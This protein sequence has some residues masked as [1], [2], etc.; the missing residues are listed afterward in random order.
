VPKVSEFFGISIY[1][2]FREHPPPHFHAR[3]AEEEV[4]IA[5]EDLSVLAGTINPRALGLVIEWA[6]LHRDDLRRAWLQ[7]Q[8][9]EAPDKIEPLR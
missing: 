8:A 6:T 3:Y 1:L 9:H 4:L 2:Y 5:I 7:A